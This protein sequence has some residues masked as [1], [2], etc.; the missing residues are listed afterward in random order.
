MKK[1]LIIV[2]MMF[3]MLFH[4]SV[5]AEEDTGTYRILRYDVSLVPRSD[6]TVEVEY[7]QRWKVESGH[8]PWVTVGM[9]TGD[10]AVSE[11]SGSGARIKNASEGSWSG[12]RIDLDRDY[13]P[14]EIFEFRYKALQGKLFWGDEKDYGLDFTPG[15]YDRC[16]IDTLTVS[17]GIKAPM[18]KV[19]L[20][21]GG[22]VVNGETVRWTWNTVGKGERKSVSI[23][24]PKTASPQKFD[25]KN[26][27]EKDNLTGLWIV[28]GVIAIIVIIV[29][30]VVA[31]GGCDDDDYGSGGGFYVGSSGGGSSGGRSSSGGGSFGGRASSCA[32]ACVACACACACAGGGGAGCDRKNEHRCDSCG[33]CT[34]NLNQEPKGEK[35]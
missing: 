17:V 6:G 25:Q 14:G 7:C 30:I 1:W 20:D 27:R 16:F 24:F 31:S 35:A 34:D 5:K 21:P 18:K 32:C 22:Y 15:W 12:V 11:V 26:L 9:P 19:S 8:I 28:L 2:S 13:R 33:S 10:F 23:R 29:I 4:G 3:L